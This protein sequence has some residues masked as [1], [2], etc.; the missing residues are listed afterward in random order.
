MDL[1]IHVF[2][3]HEDGPAAEELDDASCDVSAA[4]HWLL[5][6]GEHLAYFHQRCT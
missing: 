3:L 6:N 1:L 4:N 5:P 2:R